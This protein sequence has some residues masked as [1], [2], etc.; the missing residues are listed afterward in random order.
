M[1]EE[2]L[3]V[4]PGVADDDAR[5][6]N[7]PLL[8][9]RAMIAGGLMAGASVIANLKRPD[10]PVRMLG[11]AKL[12]DIIPKQIGSWTYTTADGLVLPPPDQMRDRIYSSLLTRYYASPK[13][14]PI[15]LLV[16]YS[17]SQDG[18]IQVHRPEVCYPA[19]GYELSGEGFE[20]IDAGKGVEVPGHYFSARSNTRQEQLIYWTRIGDAFP[21][22]W[23]AQHVAVAEENLKGHIPDGVL[24]RIS[25]A[26]PDDK[27]AKEV[28]LKFIETMAHSLPPRGR[29]VMFG[30]AGAPGLV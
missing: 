21:T 13:E 8:S 24:V 29:L 12:D 26:A 7:E 19:A 10:I 5:E 28:L 6:D 14:P 23:W 9:R 18:M 16:A 25:T 4:P 1:S 15:M 30:H 2:A 3:P 11:K 17:A 22:R 20:T 27:Q